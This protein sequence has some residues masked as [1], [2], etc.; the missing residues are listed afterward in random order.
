ADRTQ[1]AATL[2]RAPSAHGIVQAGTDAA[3]G[4]VNDDG[5]TA[6]FVTSQAGMDGLFHNEGVRGFIRTADTVR[7]DGPVAIGDY[8]NDGALDLFVAGSGLWHND[9][10]ARFARDGRSLAVLERIRA[11]SPSAV[12]FVDYDNDGW[13]DLLVTGPHGPP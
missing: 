3:V 13:L 2:P 10:N 1:L 11:I 9:G 12:T 7:G 8:D 4:D 6:V 5:R